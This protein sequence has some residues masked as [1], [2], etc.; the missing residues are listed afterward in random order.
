MKIRNM[1]RKLGDRWTSTQEPHFSGL[2]VGLDDNDSPG[3][4]IFFLVMVVAIFF[5]GW[6][7]RQAYDVNKYGPAFFDAGAVERSFMDPSGYAP[8][9]DRV[10]VELGKRTYWADRVEIPAGFPLVRVL[11]RGKNTLTIDL[12]SGGIIAEQE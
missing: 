8:T 5:G 7:I 4:W 6:F 11:Y 2:A 1:R 12:T 9:S 3:K 10:R